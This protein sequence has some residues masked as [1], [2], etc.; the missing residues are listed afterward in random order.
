MSG[1]FSI[2]YS[3]KFCK[4]IPANKGNIPDN[5]SPEESW[6]EIES[7]NFETEDGCYNYREDK[8]LLDD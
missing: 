4:Y 6:C 5:W 7:D 3:C 2:C 1:L 8:T